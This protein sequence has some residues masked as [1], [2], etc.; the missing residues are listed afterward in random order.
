[1]IKLLRKRHLQMWTG[2]AVLLPIGIISAWL[3]IPSSVSNPLLQPGPTS[4]LP[5]QLKQVILPG[6]RISLRAS[7]DSM[8]WQLEWINGKTLDV[9]SGFVF[10]TNNGATDAKG[11]ELIGRI[12]ERGTYRW[13]ISRDTTGRGLHLLF[14]DIFH[15]QVIDRIN[16]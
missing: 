14:Y 6:S 2:L 11:A 4:P 12:G 9:P 7:T 1:M 3:V 10:R 13:T 8:T 15:H 5:I 16:F